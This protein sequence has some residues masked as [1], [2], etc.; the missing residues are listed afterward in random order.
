MALI[1]FISE[2]TK[3]RN[4]VQYLVRINLKT[5]VPVTIG[6]KFLFFF[7]SLARTLEM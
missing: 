6:S 4:D 5:I 3:F 7:I 2:F 1:E